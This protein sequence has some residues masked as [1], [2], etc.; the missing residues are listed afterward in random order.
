MPHANDTAAT[1]PHTWIAAAVLAAGGGCRA[2]SPKDMSMPGCPMARLLPAARAAAKGSVMAAPA[3]L[4]DELPEKP[5]AEGSR[6]AGQA[7]TTAPR[8]YG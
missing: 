1:T 5:C 8:N 3:V 6:E 4:K 7:T 2:A